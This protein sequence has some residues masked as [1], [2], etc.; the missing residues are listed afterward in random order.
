MQYV[1]MEDLDAGGRIYR[2]GNSLQSLAVM[3]QNDSITNE[4]A[5][6]A[7]GTIQGQMLDTCILLD[8]SIGGDDEGRYY[9]G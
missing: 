5:V 6:R 7:L 8:P 2:L 9:A 4:D 3:L 1:P